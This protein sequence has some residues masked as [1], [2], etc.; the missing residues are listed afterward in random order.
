MEA[1]PQ[2]TIVG[3]DWSDEITGNKSSSLQ[4][5]QD[6]GTLVKTL[7]FGIHFHQHLTQ[8]IAFD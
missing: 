1:I 5:Q 8:K 2:V 3:F 4:R 7:Y 6:I